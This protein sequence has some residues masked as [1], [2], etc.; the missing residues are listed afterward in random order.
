[1]WF[2]LI[3]EDENDEM[4]TEKNTDPKS[5]WTQYESKLDLM[6]L[7]LLHLLKTFRNYEYLFYL[8]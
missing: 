4:L 7:S 6:N 2:V 3:D 5:P 8:P 1:M